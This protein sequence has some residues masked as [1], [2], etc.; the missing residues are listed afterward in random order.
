MREG[1]M[2]EVSAERSGKARHGQSVVNGESTKSRGGKMMRR[3][4]RNSNRVQSAAK[5]RRRR[6]LS[7]ARKTLQNLL[8][9]AR[10]DVFVFSEVV[11]RQPEA[12]R[13][14]S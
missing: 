12:V 9:P 3:Q 2:P 10:R 11:A 5:R 1:R 8:F 14:L 4:R 13:V 7:A 6:R